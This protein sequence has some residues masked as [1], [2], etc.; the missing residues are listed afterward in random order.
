[1]AQCFPPSF[2]VALA[3]V[4]AKKYLLPASGRANFVFNWRV[5]NFRGGSATFTEE[6]HRCLGPGL[7]V[8]FFVDA[9]QVGADGAKADAEAVADFAIKINPWPTR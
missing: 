1:L 7:D 4:I 2:I 6:F 8:K 9:L 5:A 3:G